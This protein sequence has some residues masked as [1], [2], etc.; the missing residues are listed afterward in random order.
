M[1]PVVVDRPFAKTVGSL[2]RLG[3]WKD[4]QERAESAKHLIAAR[5]LALAKSE[6]V[7]VDSRRF[8]PRPTL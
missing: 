4:E 1:V 7:R 6:P 5:D 3:W 8:A 2:N